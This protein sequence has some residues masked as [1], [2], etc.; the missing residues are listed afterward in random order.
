MGATVGDGYQSGHER[1]S[2]H[3]D[4]EEFAGLTVNKAA[5]VCCIATFT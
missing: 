1:T 3:T 5:E 4:F 2:P